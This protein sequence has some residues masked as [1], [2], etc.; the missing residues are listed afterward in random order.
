ML[1]VPC[2]VDVLD[3]ERLT[4]AA[5]AFARLVQIASVGLQEGALLA[6]RRSAVHHGVQHVERLEH[7]AHV[8]LAKVELGRLLETLV[9]H[10]VPQNGHAY[11]LLAHQLGLVHQRVVVL[12]QHLQDARGRHIALR[13]E[14]CVVVGH[15]RG[16]HRGEAGGCRAAG[17][18]RRVAREYE[19]VDERLR[20]HFAEV[21][22]QVVDEARHELLVGV[23]A[24][25]QLRNDLQQKY[26]I[27]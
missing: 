22:Q 3:V 25:Y 6:R 13:H 14:V 17:P 5:T 23:D 1:L 19:P 15:G 7:A 16:G 8:L 27:F 18:A 24:R 9:P 4:V 2:R 26:L 10:L 20:M 11:Q 21:E 12:A